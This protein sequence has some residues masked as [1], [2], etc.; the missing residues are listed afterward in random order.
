MP[1]IV[2]MT[3]RDTDTLWFFY[4]TH[5]R[6]DIAIPSG[7]RRSRVFARLDDYDPETLVLAQSRGV[8]GA[9]HQVVDA[10]GQPLITFLSSSTWLPASGSASGKAYDSDVSTATN[11]Q[12]F[13]DTAKD[14]WNA[15]DTVTH[16]DP[17]DK[18]AETETT[19]G[20]SATGSN[21]TVKWRDLWAS[22]GSANPAVSGSMTWTYAGSGTLNGA[23]NASN[24]FDDTN[25]YNDNGST[26]ATWATGTRSSWNVMT[27][28]AGASVTQSGSMSMSANAT[29][30]FALNSSGAWVQSTGT[31]TASGN[32]EIAASYSTNATQTDDTISFGSGW[33]SYNDT[34]STQT[35]SGAQFWN[36]NYGYDATYSSASGSTSGSWTTDGS[37]TTNSSGWGTSGY[38]NGMWSGSSYSSV[39]SG[40]DYYNSLNSK[41]SASGS[42]S[43]S[44]N[45]TYDLQTVSV[46]NASGATTTTTTADS[47]SST[48]DA[49]YSA[50]SS[51]SSV[52]KTWGS[53]SSDT[54]DSWLSSSASESNGGSSNWS[55]GY[56]TVTPPSGSATTTGSGSGT[57]TAWG[58]DSYKSSASGWTKAQTWGAEEYGGGSYQNTS[59][60]TGSQTTAGNDH[61]T[62][63]GGWNAAV[64]S[65]GSVVV[66][67]YGTDTAWGSASGMGVSGW[68]E[69]YTTY[70][71]G[72]GGGPPSSFTTT[73]S[74]GGHPTDWSSSYSDTKGSPQFGGGP[75]SGVASPMSSSTPPFSATIVGDVLNKVGP[76]P[77]NGTQ[78]PQGAMTITPT[79]AATLLNQAATN[80]QDALQVTP[81]LFAAGTGTQ[82]PKLPPPD[83]TPPILPDH[84]PIQRPDGT[85]YHLDGSPVAPSE[86]YP[87]PPIPTNP[88]YLKRPHS[89][90][91]VPPAAFT[92]EDG[93]LYVL[94]GIENGQPVYR[95]AEPVQIPPAAGG[96]P[97]KPNP[98]KSKLT[99]EEQAKAWDQIN[100]LPLPDNV[101]KVLFQLVCKWAISIDG[102]FGW[103]VKGNLVSG[104]V[105]I[106]PNGG[107]IRIK[108][109]DIN[110]KNKSGSFGIEY[111]PPIP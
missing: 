20:T 29:V 59:V 62:Y 79:T 89:D 60:G 40:S 65:S 76:V 92:D 109:F 69:N 82:P 19:T 2:G 21:S 41:Q 73:S 48:W 108:K 87:F 38:S 25:I 30:G 57:A 9:T 26:S 90:S 8:G 51:G 96:Q 95:K 97:G 93:N 61:Y 32:G 100:K 43:G 83:W 75:F 34:S 102:I 5:L 98:Q 68:T 70:S 46:L 101:K 67:P 36:Q 7:L 80:P 88:D 1:N 37:A 6:C 22:V 10:C 44:T 63:S 104:F 103:K 31:A 53:N 91:A 64:S 50:S 17:D 11:K 28:S 3:N 16:G 14:N 49:S 110:P 52:L 39:S 13:G 42:A 71:P 12:T 85:W 55:E 54:V 74:G 33:S 66:T 45:W 24:S 72:L 56:T 81:V 18:G 15:A 27:G 105:I 23:M 35:G 94:E 106:T 111:Q 47:G 99:P 77:F 78:A 58:S 107:F 86:V 84:I 4:M